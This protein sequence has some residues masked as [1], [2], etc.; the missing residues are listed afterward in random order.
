[1]VH[2]YTLNSN[3]M[4]T[5][6]LLSKF[7][8]RDRATIVLDILDTIKWESKGK[9]KTSI[10]RAANLNFDQVN[11][12]LDHLLVNGFIRA[13]NSIARQEVARYKLTEKGIR[14]ANLLNSLRETFR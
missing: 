2:V 9:T 12:Y 13:E 8:H 3:V 7:K 6:V 14:T 5:I 4:S 10:M 1:V 11:K